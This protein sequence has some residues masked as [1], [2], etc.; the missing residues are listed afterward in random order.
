MSSSSPPG[1]PLPS[2]S[3]KGCFHWVFF[4]SLYTYL[5]LLQPKC[6]KTKVTSFITQK[7]TQEELSS[8]WLP[9]RWLSLRREKQCDM[10]PITHTQPQLASLGGN[11]GNTLRGSSRSTNLEKH[12]WDT[13][14]IRVA[15]GRRVCGVWDHNMGANTLDSGM[16]SNWHR[17][18]TI[19]MKL[20]IGSCLT[21][22]RKHRLSLT[23]NQIQTFS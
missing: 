6:N 10:A 17:L 12:N 9:R 22:F 13:A 16:F 8:A 15:E 4:P 21:L 5:W 20:F 7:K 1:P 14:W 19:C 23:N 2:T 18:K 11:N 3:L